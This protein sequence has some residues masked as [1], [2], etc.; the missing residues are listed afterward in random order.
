M[1]CTKCGKQNTRETKFCINCGN[2][3]NIP[4]AQIA[5]ENAA[6]G[7]TPTPA[8]T[9]NNP[10]PEKPN[11][12][13]TP[14]P[15]NPVTI[16]RE[17]SP[18]PPAQE[19]SANYQQHQSQG[20]NN[21]NPKSTSKGKKGTIIIIILL[22]LIAGGAGGYW[23]YTQQQAQKYFSREYKGDINNQY[24]SIN[25]VRQGYVLSGIVKYDPRI[26]QADLLLQGTVKADESF[27]LY[28]SDNSFSYNGIFVG[29]SIIRGS[30]S[31]KGNPQLVAFNLFSN[32]K[33]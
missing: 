8:S 7:N 5:V 23:Y 33:N 15:V 19:K 4:A 1:F 14:P 10:A 12:V 16:Q 9:I 28:P 26:K 20:S 29:K 6:I 27:S 21:T 31:L 3:L 22:L 17:P 11:V 24:V 18:I 2:K 30:V 13:A 32:S 25:I